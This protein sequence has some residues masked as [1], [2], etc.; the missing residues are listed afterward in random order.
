MDKNKSK[1]KIKDKNMSNADKIGS[2]STKGKQKT[3]KLKT[4]CKYPKDLT[5]ASANWK[6][7]SQTLN[8]NNKNSDKNKK[9]IKR[10]RIKTSVKNDIW[11]DNVDRCLIKSSMAD[12]SGTN[13]TNTSKS[14]VKDK[15]FSGL[16][17]IVAMD[18]EMVGTGT[19]GSTSLLARVSIVNFFGH[20]IYDKFVKTIEEVTDYRTAFSGVRPSDLVN[21]PDFKTVQKEVH[22]ILKD[23]IIVGHALQN[24]FK[25]LL[26][27]HPKH[28]IRDTSV[29]FRKLLGGRKPS[30][31]SLSES[32][33]G[34]K[35]Q[36]GEHDSVEDARAAMRLFTMFRKKW[37]TDLK[38]N[39]TK[40]QKTIK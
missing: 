2:K 8:Q 32:V 18:C 21:A 35:V 20:C 19:D 11:F 6:R 33:L 5:E 25:A 38:R 23:R 34:V 27:S 17:N 16:T 37:E 24:D 9:I 30:L 22:Q 28:K 15:S 3:K 29:Y 7:L 36:S 13:E 31:K 26:L 4:I 10:D 40:H 1:I 14:L 12:S 39:K